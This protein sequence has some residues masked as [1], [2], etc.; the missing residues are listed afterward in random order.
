MA[1]PPSPPASPAPHQIFQTQPSAWSLFEPASKSGSSCSSVST[2][3][4]YESEG[5]FVDA[6]QRLQPPVFNFYGNVIP[7]NDHEKPYFSPANFVPT[8]AAY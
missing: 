4:G 6:G 5:P 1:L 3:S 8:V 7:M 2:D